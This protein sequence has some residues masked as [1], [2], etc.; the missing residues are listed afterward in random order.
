MALLKPKWLFD[1]DDFKSS[2]NYKVHV[3]TIKMGDVEDPE[4][5]VAEP[6]FEWQ[7]TE[8]GKWIMEHSSPAPS[9]HRYDDP[10]FY[11]Y[12]FFICAYLNEKDYTYYRLK[13][14]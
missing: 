4:V 5:Y 13:Y 3:H 14:E 12:T 7:Q 10:M 6:I 2:K 8:K 9:F 11:G 1:L